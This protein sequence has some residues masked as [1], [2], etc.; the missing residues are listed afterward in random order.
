MGTTKA[1]LSLDSA[2]LLL[3]RQAAEREDM[4]VS[5][6]VSRAMR[7]EIQRSYAATSGGAA[8]AAEE[9]AEQERSTALGQEA[10]DHHA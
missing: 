5:Q 4:S 6:W 1:T 9:W 2:A 8:E 10:P 7:N 3:A